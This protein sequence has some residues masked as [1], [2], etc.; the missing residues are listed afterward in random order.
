[1]ALTAGIVGLPNVDK[2]TLLITITKQEQRQT[3]HC[4]LLVKRWD[5]GS[6]R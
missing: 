2:S 1:M 5:G 6:S 3:T 4:E